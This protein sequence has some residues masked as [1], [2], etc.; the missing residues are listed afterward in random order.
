[1]SRQ[2]EV[3]RP[4]PSGPTSLSGRS[5]SVS[6]PASAKI[7]ESINPMSHDWTR[8]TQSPGITSFFLAALFS[9]ALA[10]GCGGSNPKGE[11]SSG[12]KGASP[13]V[14]AGGTA[15]A[16]TLLTE[17]EIA[18]VVGNPVIKGQPFAGPEVCKWDTE[19]P[20]HV[21]MLLTVRLAGSVR[22]K[23]LCAELRKS[24]ES[25]GRIAGIGDV[26]VWKFSSMGTAFNSGDLE[27]CGEKCYL[28]LSLNGKRDENALKE[29]ALKLTQKV[30]QRL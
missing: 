16:C 2:K 21:S 10:V 9:T 14:I 11:T 3:T 7:G 28:S 24:C 8:R 29:A 12:T 19:N 23:I 26:A 4:T 15:N 5:S 18:E 13:T 22:E 30:I 17:G 20:D 1:M 6:S 25:G 27:T